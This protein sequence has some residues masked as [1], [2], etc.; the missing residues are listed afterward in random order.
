M[1]NLPVVQVMAWPLAEYEAGF[2]AES[3]RLGYAATAVRAMGRL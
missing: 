3:E 1:G 2:R